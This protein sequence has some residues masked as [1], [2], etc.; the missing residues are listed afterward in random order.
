MGVVG[1]QPTESRDAINGLN[2]LDMAQN[3]KSS[4]GGCND[5]RYI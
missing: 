2:L 1:R 5:E 3:G 4:V